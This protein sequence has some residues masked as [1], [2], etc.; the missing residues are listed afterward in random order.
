MPTAREKRIHSG[1]DR[2]RVKTQAEALCSKRY[3]QTRPHHPARPAAPGQRAEPLKPVEGKPLA[4]GK[5]PVQGSGLKIGWHQYEPPGQERG[6]T[7]DRSPQRPVDAQAC[8][9]ERKVIP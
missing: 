9:I 4:E 5:L 8:S 2:V 6:E 3:L 1:P 7:P